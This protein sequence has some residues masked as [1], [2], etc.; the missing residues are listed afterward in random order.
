MNDVIPA[1]GMLLVF[2][3][4][5][6]Q[7]KVPTVLA[8]TS[9]ASVIDSWLWLKSPVRHSLKTI[10]LLNPSVTLETPTLADGL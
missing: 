2:P 7:P 6:Q 4:L 1:P 9:I 5:F 10:V 3:L 8:L